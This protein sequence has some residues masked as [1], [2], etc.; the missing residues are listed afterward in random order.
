M[1]RSSAEARRPLWEVEV[2]GGRR[3]NSAGAHVEGVR[4]T[5]WTWKPSHT[6]PGGSSGVFSY[7]L[8]SSL[9]FCTHQRRQEDGNLWAPETW[10]LKLE[11]EVCGASQLS[12]KDCLRCL[13]LAFTSDALQRALEPKSPLCPSEILF[14]PKYL[15]INISGKKKRNPTA[16]IWVYYFCCPGPTLSPSCCIGNCKQ[17]QISAAK[18]VSAA[19]LRGLPGSQWE[20]ADPKIT[21]WYFLIGHFGNL[22]SQEGCS[23]GLWCHQGELGHLSLVK[24]IG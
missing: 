9:Q 22:L 18:A 17:Q 21:T 14:P 3:R 2:A 1:G 7:R 23:A 19:K 12:Q 20:R 13:T 11:L 16:K 4:E 10:R 24:T 15:E 5:A 6:N 8:T